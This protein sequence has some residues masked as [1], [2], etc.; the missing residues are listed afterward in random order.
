MTTQTDRLGTAPIGKLFL[1]MSLPII[2]GMLVNGLYNI[3]DAIFVTRGVG[4]L[5]IGGISIVFPVQML[6]FAFAAI[7]GSGAASIVSR[8]LG[9]KLHDEARHTAQTAL[10]FSIVFSVVLA[11][12]VLIEMKPILRLLGVTEALWPYSVDYLMP[13]LFATPIAIVATVFNDL[14]RAEGKMQFMMM[15]ML[16]GSV[17]NIILDA[18]FIFGFGMG[19]E[20]A[21]IATVISQ[22]AGLALAFSFYFRGKTA[23]HLSINDWTIDWKVLAGIVALGLPF[24]ISHAGA[25]FMIAVTN[26]SLSHVGGDAADIYISAYGLVG[27]VIMFVILPL[28]GIM[29]SFQTIAGYNYGAQNFTRVRNIVKLGIVTSSVLCVTVSVIM[30]FTPTTALSLFTSDPVLL[31]K[32]AEIAKVI[33]LAFSLA[34]VTFI[35]TGYFQATGHAKMALFASSA[36]VYIF[37]IP[38]LIILPRQLGIDG[39]WYAFPLSDLAACLLASV[40]FISYYRKLMAHKE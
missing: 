9:A 30:V 5:A 39:I 32:A 10:T 38:L 17:L 20:G 26:N 19:V 15:T 13:I 25:S 33:F 14:L 18:L 4:S 28:V 23:L 3:V 21:A 12:I 27:R 22:T 7:L 1:T 6:I 2:L 24:F 31:T 16:L 8:K 34:G 11:A 35:I 29:I 40:L 36:R 37:L